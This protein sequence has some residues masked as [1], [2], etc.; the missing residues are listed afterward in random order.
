[1][2]CD[3][4]TD[5]IV[6]FPHPQLFAALTV[7]QLVVT[8]TVLDSACKWQYHILILLFHI[9]A[10]PG[11]TISSHLHPCD[12][13]SKEC[14]QIGFLES[15]LIVAGLEK[16]NLKWYGHRAVKEKFCYLATP[17]SDSSLSK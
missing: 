13:Q 16:A 15:P 17:T 12:A 4:V 14:H 7:V 3:G 1:M 9:C 6:Y 5:W 2:L 8:A 11:K 10:C